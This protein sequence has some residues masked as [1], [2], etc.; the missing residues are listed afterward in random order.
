MSSSKR[1]APPLHLTRA[2]QVALVRT[3]VALMG[4]WGLSE[5]DARRALGGIGLD[6]MTAWRRGIPQGLTAQSSFRLAK[7]LQ[8]HAW[9]KVQSADPARSA[10]WMQRPNRLFDD[11][12]PVDLTFG[13]T[14][15]GIDRLLS[16]LRSAS[17]P[18]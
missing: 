12:R 15:N 1:E 4:H 10:S 16:Y 8:I 11:H 3:S 9:L 6:V 18:W 2:E 17:S 7:L 13:E 5:E 14:E